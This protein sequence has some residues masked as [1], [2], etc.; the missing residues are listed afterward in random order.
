MGGARQAAY[1]ALLRC[2]R[3]GAW[4]AQAMDAAI[5]K[6]DLDR[7]DAALATRLCLGVLQNEDYLD[8]HIDRLCSTPPEKGLRDLLR[9]GA[10]QL[11]LTDRVPLHAAVGETVMMPPSAAVM[12]ARMWEMNRI[13]AV[14]M[15]ASCATLGLPPTA[16][17]CLP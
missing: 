17:T 10:C 5:K 2:R 4:S 6:H 1:E 11:L 8:W 13:F 9:L 3:D 15:P 7:R 14:S 12:A 16:N